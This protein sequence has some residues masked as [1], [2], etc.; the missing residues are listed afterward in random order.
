MSDE[1]RNDIP[2]LVKNAMKIPR[3]KLQY[4]LGYTQAVVDAEAQKG[5]TD[6]TK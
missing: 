6:G 4:V 2:E 5:A 3:D 1:E